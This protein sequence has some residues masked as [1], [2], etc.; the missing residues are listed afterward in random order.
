MAYVDICVRDR[1]TCPAERPVVQVTQATA[2]TVELVLRN[3]DGT[4]VDLTSKAVRVRAKD[5]PFSNTLYLSKCAEIPEST[6]AAGVLRVVLRQRDLPRAG[7]FLLEFAVYTT[8]GASSSSG[9]DPVTEELVVEKRVPGY[10]EVAPS[11]TEYSRANVP[12]TIAEVRLSIRDSC[13]QDNFLLDTQ[14]FKPEEIA[15]AIRRPV[16]YWNSALPPL[17]LRY[18]PVNFPYR[19]QWLEAVAGELLTIAGMNKARNHLSYS[20]GGVSVDDQNQGSLYLQMG[21]SR[22][23]AYQNW[24]RLE[25]QAIN[26]RGFFGTTSI[27]GYG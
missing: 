27:P 20:A 24:V 4:P 21:Q 3:E 14:E 10:L 5:A 12:L 9:A 7:L 19:Y 8:S 6:A 22:K 16:D 25:K 13:A 17:N 1:E 26:A 2:S 18:T 23:D 11:L 15:W